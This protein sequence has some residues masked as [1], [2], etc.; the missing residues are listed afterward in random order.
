MMEFTGDARRE[1]PGFGFKNRYG[2]ERSL[3][4]AVSLAHYE[5]LAALFDYP[6]GR[7][8]GAG[9]KQLCDAT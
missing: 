3:R 2:K 5:Y 1:T 4:H 6:D 7:L 9:Q 8:P